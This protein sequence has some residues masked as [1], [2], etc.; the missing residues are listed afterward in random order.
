MNLA[1]CDRFGSARLR[2]SLQLCLGETKNALS[3]LI[4]AN[5][6]DVLCPQAE[7]D[8]RAIPPGKHHC[9][10]SSLTPTGR[11]IA[12]A[13]YFYPAFL[14]FSVYHSGGIQGVHAL[15]N[16]PLDML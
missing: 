15:A 8:A 14:G 5:V 4:R 16:L 10:A 13:V 9:I 7:R 3:S 11:V 1:Q 2:H 12:H 6:S